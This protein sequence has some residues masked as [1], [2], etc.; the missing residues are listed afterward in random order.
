MENNREVFK[1]NK[2]EKDRKGKTIVFVFRIIIQMQQQPSR[3]LLSMR[4][5]Q[6]RHLNLLN[7]NCHLEFQCKSLKDQGWTRQMVRTLV[8]T[9]VQPL[10]RTLVQAYNP[11]AVLAELD[12]RF[13]IL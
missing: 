8:R 10:V 2:A 6:E 4:W 5:R 7:R 3:Q 11:V 1:L 13:Y 9:L 12:I